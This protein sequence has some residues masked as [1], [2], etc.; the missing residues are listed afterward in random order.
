M[1]CWYVYSLIKFYIVSHA[2]SCFPNY[3]KIIGHTL[4]IYKIFCL[5]G[6]ISFMHFEILSNFNTHFPT[7]HT[8]KKLLNVS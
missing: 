5:V 2:G 1:K 7:F 3:L 6:E 4:T 8:I